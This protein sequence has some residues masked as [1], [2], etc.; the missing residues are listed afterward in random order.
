MINIIVQEPRDAYLI[1]I[2]A[3]HPWRKTTVP[4]DLRSRALA[5]RAELKAEIRKIDVFLDLYA[6]FAEEPAQLRRRPPPPQSLANLRRGAKT[7]IHPD[8]SYGTMN[9]EQTERY[10]Q[11]AAR[12]AP[13]AE[14]VEISGY[15]RGSLH[16]L[17]SGL[18]N[19]IKAAR[20]KLKDD[21]VWD[22]VIIPTALPAAVS[23]PSE[24][25]PTIDDVL[26]WAC[27]QGLDVSIVGSR[28]RLR[29]VPGLLTTPEFVALVNLRRTSAE[30]P[31]FVIGVNPQQQAAE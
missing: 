7:A 10:V 11:A 31:P 22:S 23:D 13:V 25:Q 24:P 14:Q 20:E 5:R 6:K 1:Y 21:E 29:G 27:G 30:M 4:E 8:G 15:A 9:A 16:N 28:Y 12:N 18:A 17:R 2:L 26:S 3:S 19:R